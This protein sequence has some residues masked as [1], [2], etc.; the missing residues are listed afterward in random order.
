MKKLSLVTALVVVLALGSAALGADVAV[1]K[2]EMQQNW[3]LSLGWDFDGE[4]RNILATLDGLGLSY[5]ELSDEQLAAGEF[6]DTKLLIMVN[7]RMMSA[8]QVEAVRAFLAGGGK[9]LGMYQ[10]SFRNEEN[11][12]VNPPNAYQLD[13][14][15]KVAYINWTGSPPMHA[16]I[17]GDTSHPIWE[18]LPEFVPTARYTAMVN[19][20]LEGATVI[21]EWYN[22]DQ[23]TKSQA[24]LFN[25]AIVESDGVIYVGESLFDPIVYA[26][27]AVKKLVQNIINYLLQ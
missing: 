26:D 20:T 24:D 15:Y 22:A 7:N 21:G 9:L 19:A 25:A 11:Q 4:Y 3:Y 23:T 6:S 18:G 16:Y 1:L 10:S 27:D 12:N 5:V 2:S 17:K 14:V 8:A 13:D